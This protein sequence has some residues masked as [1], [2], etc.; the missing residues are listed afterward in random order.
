[1]HA[2]LEKIGQEVKC[3]DCHTRNEVP[4]LKEEAGARVQGTGDRGQATE[5]PTLEGAEEFGMSEVVERPKYRPLVRG[6]E[7]YDVL[8]AGDP[9]AIEHRLTTGPGARS[10]GPGARR[11]A[12]ADEESEEI[13]LAPAEERT[14]AGRDPRSVLPQPE[15]EPEDPM[16]DGRYDDGVIGDRVDP[17]S[18]D[19]WKQ[20]PM[21]YGIVGF[22]RRS[23][24]L[25]RLVVFA[26]LLAVVVLLVR[27]NVDLLTNDGGPAQI[28]GLLMMGGTIGATAVC[29]FSFAAAFQAVVEATGNGDD[30]VTTWPDWNIL[31]WF[32]PAMYVGA[33]LLIAASPGA[34]IAGWTL[35]VNSDDWQ[36]A[37]FG[38]GAPVVISLMVLFPFVYSS[39]LVEDSV[40]AIASPHTLR[41]LKSASDGWVFF[42]MYSLALV[43]L[44]GLAVAMVVRGEML[45][46]A[47]GAAGTVAAGL[48]YARLLGRLMWVAA[49][50][51]A[52]EE[53]RQGTGN[54]SQ[55][56]GVRSQ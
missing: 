30:E 48:L 51:E 12:I 3:P 54:R 50:R 31:L 2:P 6:R 36:M 40:M 41:S 16:Y 55:G 46:A 9:A 14:E 45:G 42:Y 56:T 11:Q 53:R 15:L 20:A 49:Q 5:T 7:E 37:A 4:A 33:A 17:R 29:L 32:G 25:L 19:A 24:T 1:M 22:L 47:V 13:S 26:I 38:I 43:V 39:M 27:R 10:Q 8:S 35:A 28:I 23:S 34:L 52:A 18:P 21:V 44:A